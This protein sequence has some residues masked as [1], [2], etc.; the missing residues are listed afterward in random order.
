MM[1]MMIRDE[2][3]LVLVGFEVLTAVSTASTSFWVFGPSSSKEVYRRFREYMETQPN[4]TALQPRKNAPFAFLVSSPVSQKSY[5][6]NIFLQDKPLL[7]TP[8]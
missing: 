3:M 8:L 7:T 1:M 4:Y 5:S 6:T 2:L